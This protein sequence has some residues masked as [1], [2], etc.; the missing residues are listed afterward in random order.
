MRTRTIIQIICLMGMGFGLSLVAYSLVNMAR[1]T[2]PTPNQITVIES[3]LSILEGQVKELRHVVGLENG[4][5]EGLQNRR[6]KP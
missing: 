1:P 6:K 5:S 3:R 4:L 2:Q